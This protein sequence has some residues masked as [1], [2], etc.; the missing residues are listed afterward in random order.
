MFSQAKEVISFPPFVFIWMRAAL[1]Q[2]YSLVSVPLSILTKIHSLSLPCNSCWS[3]KNWNFLNWCNSLHCSF[4]QLCLLASVYVV[5]SDCSILQESPHWVNS[6]EIFCFLPDAA[7]DTTCARTCTSGLK[8][9]STDRWATAA[10]FNQQTQCSNSYVNSLFDINIT[11]HWD[12]IL[13]VLIKKD[14]NKCVSNTK[15][16][17]NGKGS[18]MRVKTS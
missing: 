17:A 10:P 4:L 13:A 9:C 8:D 12:I 1:F 16:N 6:H 5:V 2:Q 7:P 14:K 3:Q 11:T 18:I 15:L